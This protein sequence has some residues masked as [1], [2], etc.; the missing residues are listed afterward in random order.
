M[1][2]YKIKAKFVD[3]VQEKQLRRI[4]VRLPVSLN[5]GNTQ[6]LWEDYHERKQKR[7]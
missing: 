4:T 1:I 5:S 3:V 6:L 7:T 2:Y